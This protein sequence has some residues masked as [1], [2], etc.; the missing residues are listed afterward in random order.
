MAQADTTDTTNPPAAEKPREPSFLPTDISPEEVFR[1]IGRLRKEARDEI[2][3]LIQFLDQTDNHMER[4]QAVDDVACDDNE[5]EVGE[6]DDEPSL[7]SH[8]MPSGA[9]SYSMPVS[10]NGDL[11]CEG[12]DTPSGRS[13]EDEPSLGSVEATGNGPN[14]EP[15]RLNAG[16]LFLEPF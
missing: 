12:D 14:C 3:R 5:L 9:V 15:L 4:E 11:D 10:R 6:G 7:G 2:H 13:A 8:V 1:A 16:G